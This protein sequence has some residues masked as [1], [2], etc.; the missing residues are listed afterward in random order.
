MRVA[1]QI[2]NQENGAAAVEFALLVPALALLVLGI[3][4]FG[5][6]FNSY[7]QVTHAAREGVRWAALERTVGEVESFTIA[8]AP[9]LNP[10]LTAADI[11]IFL[12]EGGTESELTTGGATINDQSKPVKVMVS[13]AMPINVPIMQ[14]FL[15]STLTLVSSA[16]QKVE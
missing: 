14:S 16:T 3:I 12:I 9:T 8:A 6:V 2:L 10:S 13:Y 4:Q 11:R 5:M 7:L 15:G 1:K